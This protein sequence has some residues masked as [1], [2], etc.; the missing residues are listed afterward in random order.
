MKKT[1]SFAFASLIISTSQIWAAEKINGKVLLNGVHHSVSFETNVEHAKTVNFSGK[2]FHI[3]TIDSSYIEAF[4]DSASIL[5][6]H[7]EAL[8]KILRESKTT[9]NNKFN[10]ENIDEVHCSKADSKAFLVISSAGL[11]FANCIY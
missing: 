2:K 7:G 5:I 11:N 3:L 6:Y 8:Q 10:L 1:V 4:S 9:I